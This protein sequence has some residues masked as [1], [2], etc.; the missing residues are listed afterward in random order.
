MFDTIIGTFEGY[1]M[2]KEK[3]LFGFTIVFTILISILL[4]LTTKTPILIT[5]GV[6]VET[7]DK[8]GQEKIL[9]N[10]RDGQRVVILYG[11]N[12]QEFDHIIDVVY[13]TPD[14]YW[15]DMKYRALSIGDLHILALGQKYA[16]IEYLDNLIDEKTDE[17]L[18]ELITDSMDDFEKTLKIHDW[19]CDHVRYMETYNDGDQEVYG[20]LIEKR[21]RC[22]GY[23]KLF[24]IMLDKVGIKSEVISGESL[25]DGEKV[26]HAWNL[27]YMDG[28]PYYF[29]ITWDDNDEIGWNHHWFAVTQKE[30]SKTHFPSQGYDWNYDAN[31]TEHNYYLRNNMYLEKY[32]YKYI[33]NMINQYGKNFSLK[34]ENADLMNHT[35]EMI[36]NQ[37]EL[38]KI[39]R[40]S[41]MT[42]VKQITYE[43][44]EGVNCLHLNFE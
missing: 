28:K 42:Y 41:N 2:R 37:T 36:T 29:D 4:Y 5:L 13:D 25:D 32:Y 27:V 39:M 16:D 18:K 6:A 23:A 1:K 35:I 43:M 33:S 19:I 3:K 30:F 21:A 40:E 20:A 15:L 38:K 9:E 24:T 12:N 34:F 11:M 8:A 31:H 44:S 26:P 17:V 14:F 10:I 7:N 22:A